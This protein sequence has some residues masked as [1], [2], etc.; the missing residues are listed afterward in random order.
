LLR[1]L[2]FGD[3]L[4]EKLELEFELQVERVL[5]ELISHSRWVRHADAIK[6]FSRHASAS[7]S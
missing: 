7:C 3:D 1:A 2:T 6:P 4:E 5:L